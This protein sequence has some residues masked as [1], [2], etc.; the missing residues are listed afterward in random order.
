ME[1]C[2]YSPCSSIIIGCNLYSDNTGTTFV[3]NGFYSDGTN[4]YQ[5]SGGTVINISECSGDPTGTC[6][7]LSVTI[8]EADISASDDS[9][10]TMTYT[11]CT[12][13]SFATY[14]FNEGG[15]WL[16]DICVD[17]SSGFA[18]SYLDGGVPTNSG[19]S[20]ASILGPCPLPFA[21]NSERIDE[22]V[23]TLDIQGG[24][25][26]ER[27]FL[28]F[29]VS[30]D[31]EFNSLNFSSPV[32]VSVLDMLHQTRSGYMDLDVSGNGSSNYDF[33]PTSTMASCLVTITS[34]SSGLTTGVGD[35]TNII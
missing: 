19:S 12:G 7:R 3:G 1:I 4:C 23:G 28:D 26:N 25:P 18:F 8:S 2:F 31:G 27:I 10:V 33:D 21:I 22:G 29:V 35:E 17:D 14:P 34:R 11:D 9:T 24:E 5:V 15:V 32:T 20:G 30:P 6:K 13:N 16:V